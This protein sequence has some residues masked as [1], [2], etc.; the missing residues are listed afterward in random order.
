[1]SEDDEDEDE[2]AEKREGRSDLRVALLLLRR[3]RTNGTSALIGAKPT[4]GRPACVNNAVARKPRPMSANAMATKARITAASPSPPLLARM[5]APV[6]TIP[7]AG[8]SGVVRAF[9]V[10]AD[11]S[12][13]STTARVTSSSLSPAATRLSISSWS[14]SIDGIVCATRSAWR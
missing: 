13:C 9:T 2:K 11:F 3:S 1:V 7:A 8:T 5:P 12:K 6:T 4:F 10:A 14:A